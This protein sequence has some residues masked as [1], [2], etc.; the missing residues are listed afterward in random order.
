MMGCFSGLSVAKLLPL[1]SVCPVRI[2]PHLGLRFEDY[3]L[4]PKNGTAS[5]VPQNPHSITPP[6]AAK[7]F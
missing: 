2:A 6:A 3:P 7:G 1:C 5:A 4:K